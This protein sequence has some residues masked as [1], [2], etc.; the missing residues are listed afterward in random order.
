MRVSEASLE[1][2]EF[3]SLRAV[4]AEF[5]AS[6]LGR[7]V[8]LTAL[9]FGNPAELRRSLELTANVERLLEAAPL[10]GSF[11]DEIGPLA[12]RIAKDHGELDGRDLLLLSV[13]LN[14]CRGALERIRADSDSESLQAAWSE[15]PDLGPLADEIDRTIDERG[16]VRDSASRRLESLTRKSRK[17][18]RD[19]YSRLGGFVTEQRANLAEETISVQDGRLVLMLR[20]GSKGRLP[21]VVQGRSSTGKSFYFEPLDFV[22]ENNQ[23]TESQR[24]E[25]AE[26]QRI[27]SDL[28]DR[29]RDHRPGI[30]VYWELLADLDARQALVRLKKR[31]DGHFAEPRAGDPLQLVDARHPLLDPQLAEYRERA[32]GHAGHRDAVVPLAL[33]LGE[34]ERIQVVTGPNAGGKTVALKTVGL[35]TLAAHSGFPLPVGLHSRLPFVSQV[36]AVIGDEQDLLEERSTFS[37]RLLRLQEAWEAARADSLLLIDEL[38]SGTDP[39]EGSAL[40]IALLEALSEKRPWTV[41]TTHLTAIA[42]AALELD[43]ASCA[44]MEFD[45]ESGRPTYRLVPGPPGGSE[46]LALGRRLGLADAWLSRAEEIL[47][48]EERRLRRLLQEVESAKRNLERDR[49]ELRQARSQAVRDRREAADLLTEA[50]REKALTAKR[51]KREYREFRDQVQRKLSLEVERLSKELENGHRRSAAGKAVERL[52]DEVPTWA[53]PSGEQA[54]APVVGDGVEHAALGWKGKLVLLDGS[55]ATVLVHGKRVSCGA[56]EL[57]RAEVVT[58]P[59][60]ES[61]LPV[62][63]VDRRTQGSSATGVELMLI[64]KRVEP[65]LEDLERFLDRALLGSEEVVRIVH[66]HGTGRLRSAIRKRLDRHPAVASWSPAG[67]SD[68]GDGATVV[69]LAD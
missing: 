9:P 15:V 20:A 32:L 42:A 57:V 55:K 26:R 44:A 68:G 49:D 28:L 7:R 46:A 56:A 50:G 61:R 18:R 16:R 21:G 17:A 6:D 60:A 39:T 47:G 63:P 35:L 51:L 25:E 2:L 62:S 38:G 8:L 53:A 14:E 54:E 58:V 34:S 29:V 5:A 10:V 31:M 11:E 36:V 4:A 66:G 45:S 13:V 52:F 64:G 40:G 69:R 22:E 30:R 43:N 67:E 41:I 33:G 23:L 27:L 1:A 3:D 12:G 37:G 65:A 24:D 48:P 59:P 19:L